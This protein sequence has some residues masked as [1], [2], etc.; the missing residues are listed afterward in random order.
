ML[1]AFMPMP[2]LITC[3]HAHAA[4]GAGAVLHAPALH[5]LLNERLH[6]NVE[7]LG[8][9]KVRV[10]ARLVQHNLRDAL[11]DELVV[12]GPRLGIVA[13]ADK[14]LQHC[15]RESNIIADVSSVFSRCGTGT[16]GT[17]TFL[18]VEPEP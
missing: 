1:P 8:G 6:V 5:Q 4:V 16:V 3:V 11:L 18:L 12:G 7:S 10:A 17:V 15:R 2:L 9:A 13:Y 14:V